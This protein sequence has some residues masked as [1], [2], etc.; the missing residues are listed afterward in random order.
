LLRIVVQQSRGKQIRANRVSADVVKLTFDWQGSHRGAYIAK[1][2]KSLDDDDNVE[3]A[4]HCRHGIRGRIHPASGVQERWTMKKMLLHTTVILT[5]LAGSIAVYAQMGQ[6]EGQA[7]GGGQWGHGQGQPPTAEQR[8]QR[9]TQQ[10]N[11][12]EAQQQQ[13]KPILENES[14]QTQALREDTS[15]SQQDR[16]TK[17]M[18]IRQDS[19][20]QIKP[21]LNAD[22]QKQYD[23]MMSHRGR[24]PGGPGQMQPQGQGQTP[25]PQ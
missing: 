13:I 25:P 22:Q 3:R 2:R 16:M 19:S 21:I 24:G 10:L 20:S 18:A 9:M 8:L 1:I 5:M 15:L 4:A 23:E 11:L 6:G 7:Q 17:M 12:S 14:K